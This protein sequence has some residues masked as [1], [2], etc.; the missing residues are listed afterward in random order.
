[1]SECESCGRDVLATY[2]VEREGEE[3]WV[4]LA[5]LT[6]EEYDDMAEKNRRER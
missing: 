5:E 4:C 1:M 6:P 3:V 2:R